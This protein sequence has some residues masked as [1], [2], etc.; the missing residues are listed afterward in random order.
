MKLI[1]LSDAGVASQVGYLHIAHV[2]GAYRVS[3]VIQ[4]SEGIE[5]P[6]PFDVE[7]FLELTS[8]RGSD[9]VAGPFAR[10]IDRVDVATDPDRE[11]VMETSFSALLETTD[12]KDLIVAY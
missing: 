2:N 10:E 6:S 11:L 7:L 4:Y 8:S 3:F 1:D 9:R 5:S 12:K